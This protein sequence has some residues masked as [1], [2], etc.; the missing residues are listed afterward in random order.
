MTATAP[1]N[2]LDFRPANLLRLAGFNPTTSPWVTSPLPEI[3]HY[4][5]RVLNMMNTL[6]RKGVFSLPGAKDRYISFLDTVGKTLIEPFKTSLNYYRPSEG[7]T[8]HREIRESLLITLG[9][10]SHK[11][12]LVPGL[13]WHAM[14][15]IGSRLDPFTKHSLLHDESFVIGS[16]KDND[17]ALH[18]AGKVF[19]F[20]HY[21]QSTV[22]SRMG[23]II[24]H[25]HS[26]S[27]CIK[28]TCK[29][30]YTVTEP[31]N[32]EIKGWTDALFEH[33]LMEGVTIVALDLLGDPHG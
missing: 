13:V 14:A 11:F 2:G 32:E 4:Q 18:C 21:V 30:G 7:A 15:H 20:M 9:E 31:S 28:F 25:D 16:A 10:L 17:T 19:G 24:T 22:E 26:C 33:L 29:S 6:K 3:V 5:E 8:S 27:C 12:P 23:V 1:S